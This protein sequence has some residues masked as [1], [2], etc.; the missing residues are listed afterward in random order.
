MDLVAILNEPISGNYGPRCNV[1][2]L[3]ARL[4]KT[5]P[6][7]AAA[8]RQVLGLPMDEYPATVLSRRLKDAGHGVSPFTIQRHRRGECACTRV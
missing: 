1:G 3:L 5:D 8:L 6:K 4:D 7:A 2:L